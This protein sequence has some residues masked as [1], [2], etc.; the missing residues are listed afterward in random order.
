MPTLIQDPGLE[1]CP[2]LNINIRSQHHRMLTLSFFFFFNQTKQS[3]ELQNDKVV[4]KSAFGKKKIVQ[5]RLTQNSGE[6][7]LD[8][9]SPN[10]P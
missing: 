5:K 3:L 6:A 8:G 9:L 10:D 7:F 1:V 2:I 4:W